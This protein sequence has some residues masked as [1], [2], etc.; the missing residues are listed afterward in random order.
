[1]D[2]MLIQPDYRLGDIQ[3]QGRKYRLTDLLFLLN[4]Q[5]LFMDS[6]G[7]RI[8]LLRK[9]RGLT[10]IQLRERTQIG[11]STLSELETNISQTMSVETLMAL[12]RVLTS[13]PEFIL[14]GAKD[15]ADLEA[16][17]QEAEL[18]AIFRELPASGKT[19]LVGSARLLRQAIPASSASHPFAHAPAPGAQSTSKEKNKEEK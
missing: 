4:A 18:V 12:C 5:N 19:A 1:M 11:Q 7:S 8:R 9:S 6:I 13:T 14:Y 15:E 17:L 16:S 3:A 2:C 10:Q